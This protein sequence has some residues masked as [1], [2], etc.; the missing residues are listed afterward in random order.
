MIRSSRLRLAAA[1]VAGATF[2]LLAAPAGASGGYVGAAGA[3]DPYFPMSGN[4]GYDV[5]HYGLDIGYD[6]GTG[7]LTGVATVTAVA[8]QILDTFDLDLSGLTVAG[9]A[10]NGVPARFARYGQELRVDPGAP[11]ARGARFVVV[12]RY[13]GVPQPVTDPDGSIEGWVATADGAYVVG[14]PTGS[15]TWFPADN[16]PTDKSTFTFRITVPRGLTAVANGDLVSRS[17]AGGRTTF[18]WN[19][20]EPMAPYLATATVGAFDL[21]VSRTTSGLPSYVAVEPAQADAAA[22]ALARISDILGYFGTVFGPYPFS[23]VGAVVDTAPEVGYAL[24]AQTRPV[25][26][27]APDTTSVARALAHQWFGDS[28]SVET[29]KDIWLSEGFATYAEWL[30]NEHD[31][32]PSAQETFDGLYATPADDAGLW[33][34]PPA[35]PGGPEN[36]FADSV[37]LRGAMALHTLRVTV[38]DTAFFRILRQWTATYHYGN[39]STADL[40]ALAEKVSGRQLDRLFQSWLYDAGK[41]AL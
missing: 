29:W 15:M 40:L 17:D 16:R 10:V 34:P 41:P 1:G 35:A 30:W 6:P 31:G 38:G 18:V 26:P 33:D 37:N 14:E 27:E 12:V 5:D 24:E 32:G 4:G 11:V 36:L 39:A 8:N 20:R 22:P 7:R 23:S 21:T 25:F 13:A 3:G 28:V 9:V 2:A 19:E